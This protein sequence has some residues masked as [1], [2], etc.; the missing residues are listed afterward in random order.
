MNLGPLLP[1]NS[2]SCAH[3]ALMALCPV[4]IVLALAIG[5]RTWGRL[6]K[7]NSLVTADPED[8]IVNP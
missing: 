1:E 7:R 8:S 4:L 3:I 6:R 2:S 5:L